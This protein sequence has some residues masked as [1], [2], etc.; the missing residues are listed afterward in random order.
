MQTP[1]CLLLFHVYLRVVFVDK[2]TAIEGDKQGAVPSS[3][4]VDTHILGNANGKGTHIARLAHTLAELPKLHTRLLRH[5]FG[6]VG[7]GKE[8]L[9]NPQEVWTKFG[10]NMLKFRGRQRWGL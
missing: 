9:P 7:R 1:T 8:I 4:H 2:R 3:L 6:I 10:D 5:V